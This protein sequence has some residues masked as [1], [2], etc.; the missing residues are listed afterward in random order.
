MTSEKAAR[1][2]NMR[3]LFNTTKKLA[4]KCSKSE[5]QIKNKDRKP[6]AET[7]EQLSM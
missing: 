1:K 5:R 4:E 6:I 7:Q 2:G 3:Y